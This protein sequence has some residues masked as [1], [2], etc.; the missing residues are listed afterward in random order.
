MLARY[1]VPYLCVVNCGA[2]ANVQSTAF[3]GDMFAGGIRD[4]TYN[5]QT[6]LNCGF[7]QIA[8]FNPP[9]LLNYFG[10]GWSFC[11]QDVWYPLKV[12]KDKMLKSHE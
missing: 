11:L 10:S 4:V 2:E 12:V 1:L 3:D 7:V 5:L 9:S 8:A 6:R